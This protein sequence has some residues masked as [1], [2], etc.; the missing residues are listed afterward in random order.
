MTVYY[1]QYEVPNAKHTIYIEQW[2]KDIVTLLYDTS[3]FFFY[4]HFQ[5][6]H[7]TTIKSLNKYVRPQR[8]LQY[9][10]VHWGMQAPMMGKHIGEI[11][12][13]NWLIK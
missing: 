11:H 10:T 7:A 9:N 5:T 1:R 12:T 2:L 4:I 8:E 3:L 13:V 6:L